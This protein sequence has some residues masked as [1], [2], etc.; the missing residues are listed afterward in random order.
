MARRFIAKT[1]ALALFASLSVA[2]AARADPSSSPIQI[3]QVRIF[4]NGAAPFALVETATPAVCGVA[5]FTIDLAKP[6]GAGMLSAAITAFTTRGYVV[7][8]VSNATGCAGYGTY[9]RSITLTLR[10]N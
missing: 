7:L 2:G 6:S 5:T 4:D 8:E 3:N 1:L 9:L 10:T